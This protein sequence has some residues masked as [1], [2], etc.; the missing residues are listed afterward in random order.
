MS[1]IWLGKF[2]TIW[3][4]SLVYIVG[5]VA[6]S[7]SGWEKLYSNARWLALFSLF[8][9]ALGTGGIKPNITSFVGD[10]FDPRSVEALA[11]VF[12]VFY[13][14]INSGSLCSTI[15]TPI[16]R[17]R[18]SYVLAFG[19]PAI[20]L[21]VAT[22]LFVVGGRGYTRYHVPAGSSAFTIFYR[23]IKHAW[24]E[25][26]RAKNLERLGTS[27]IASENGENG[28][29]PMKDIPFLDY[30]KPIMGDQVVEDVRVVLKVLLVFV[31]LPV[32][33]SLYDQ[34]SSRWVFMANDMNRTVGKVT[35]LTE[36]VQVLNPLLTLTMIPVFDRLIYPFFKKIGVNLHP[37]KHKMVVG[38]LLTALS[39]IV[40][41][42]LQAWMTIA[43]PKK[44]SI[45]LMVPQFWILSCAEVLVSVTGLEFAYSQ[46]PK[47]LKSIVMSGW[48]FTTAVGNGLVA[49]LALIEIG[50]RALEFFLYATLMILFTMIFYLIVKGYQVIDRSNENDDPLK[51]ERADSSFAD[52]NIA[53]IHQNSSN[54]LPILSEDERV[55]TPLLNGGKN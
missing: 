42:G 22:L 5:C 33:W 12:A 38:M 26:R 50:N 9:I 27:T 51:T 31:P 25:R 23:V 52:D 44:L 45:F 46:A 1:D 39:F 55:S 17:S 36:Q 32:F 41:G 2:K 19:V 8:L 16:I 49:L 4:M 37:L 10:Q 11:S 53:S 40:S 35:F 3:L 7:L 47:W 18:G 43:S 34:H 14:L 29:Q 24:V 15:L 13:F 54:S 6:L 20:L 48:L 28:I 21:F 30:A